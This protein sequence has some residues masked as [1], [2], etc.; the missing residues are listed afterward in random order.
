MVNE[1]YQ[2]GRQN[3][4]FF[5]EAIGVEEVIVNDFL[6]YEHNKLKSNL[7][8]ALNTL[9]NKGLIYWNKI[10]LVQEDIGNNVFITRKATEDEIEFILSIQNETLK[11]LRLN[12]LNEVYTTKSKIGKYYNIINE[13]LKETGICKFYKVYEIIYTQKYVLEALEEA[14]KKLIEEE[15]NFKKVNSAYKSIKE[16]HKNALLVESEHFELEDEWGVQDKINPLITLRASK[17]YVEKSKTVCDITIDKNN[18]IEL[19]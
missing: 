19:I 4:K 8:S 17:D 6:H 9:V 11:E 18:K 16:K 13:K 7:E 10:M 12:G 1:N 15:L 14:K 2:V 3:I 5:S